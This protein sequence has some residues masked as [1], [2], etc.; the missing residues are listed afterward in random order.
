MRLNVAN[1]TV[2]LDGATILA[3]AGLVVEAGEFV[4]LVG[5][6]GS[7]KSTLLRTIYRALRPRAGAVYVGDD[8]VWELSARA[9]AQRTA[10]VVQ[11]SGS[12]FDFTVLEVVA[13]GR[14]P[15]KGSFD[16][17]TSADRSLCDEAL[18]HVGMT[19]FAA[20]DFATLSGGEKQRVFVAR[21]IAQE[22]RLLVLD[23]PTNHLDIRF[24]LELLDLVGGL[25]VTTIAAMHDLALA[26]AHCDRIYVLDAGA[27]VACG[28]PHDVLTGELVARV[29]GVALRDWR[30]SQTGRTRL[31]FDR[32]PSAAATLSLAVT[33]TDLDDM[34]P[35]TQREEE[36]HDRSDCAQVGA[37]A[38]DVR[39]PDLRGGAG[40][41]RRRRRG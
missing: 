33:P 41:L 29:F 12:D 11:E 32:L 39:D 24:Q 27:I 38:V 1:V 26:A 31:A 10:A 15:H 28:P 19:D 5:P 36:P 25:G 23:E 37:G 22:T 14:N 8:Y 2:D 21:A 34:T 16:R 30:D 13:M 6:N 20:R 18:R 3:D 17:D 9:S 35:A 40:G 7:G 4:G